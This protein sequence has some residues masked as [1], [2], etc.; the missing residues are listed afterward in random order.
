MPYRYK[1]PWPNGQGV[2]PLIQRLRVRVPQGVLLRLLPGVGPAGLPRLQYCILQVAR[3]RGLGPW[4][5]GP[6]QGAGG[7]RPDRIENPKM[8]RDLPFHFCCFNAVGAVA[9]ALSGPPGP[10]GPS[11][12]Q[13]AGQRRGVRFPRPRGRPTAGPADL[14]RQ[15]HWGWGLETRRSGQGSALAPPRARTPQAWHLPTALA[16]SQRRARSPANVPPSI[17]GTAAPWSPVHA[18]K[19]ATALHEQ[20]VPPPI[21]G[22]IATRYAPAP[23]HINVGGVEDVGTKRRRFSSWA[24]SSLICPP[25]TLRRGERGGAEPRSSNL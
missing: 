10:Q 9:P 8:V 23:P 5:C 7:D 4:V 12:C 20:G 21:D 19:M 1:P 6:R 18:S 15:G 22:R 2:G 16:V 17:L 3:A 13:L 14:Q 24:E 11:F 25:S